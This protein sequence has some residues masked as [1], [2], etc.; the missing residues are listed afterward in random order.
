M[1][2]FPAIKCENLSP[3]LVT[4][5]N[6]IFVAARLPLLLFICWWSAYTTWHWIEYQIQFLC[7]CVKVQRYV[8]YLLFLVMW[9]ALTINK[10]IA[11]RN[12]PG[13]GEHSSSLETIT[14]VSSLSPRDGVLVQLT[15]KPMPA[16]YFLVF[17]W[18]WISSSD[19]SEWGEVGRHRWWEA[20]FIVAHWT[21]WMFMGNMW[22]HRT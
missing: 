2:V 13:W 5:L 20:S 14:L 1:Y 16:R 4:E 22:E 3:I 18:C 12:A 11:G 21:M 7:C 9:C 8:C 10:F 6:E 15:G 17:V 19:C